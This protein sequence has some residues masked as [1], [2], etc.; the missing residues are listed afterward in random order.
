M[1][2]NSLNVLLTKTN[3]TFLLMITADYSDDP[4]L[5]RNNDYTSSAL[6]QPLSWM[7]HFNFYLLFHIT[8]LGVLGDT[9]L[10]VDY[11]YRP[12]VRSRLGTFI[13]WGFHFNFPSV[14]KG[15]MSVYMMCTESGFVFCSCIVVRDQGVRAP[16]QSPRLPSWRR[17]LKKDI[18]IRFS[19]ARS[20][21]ATD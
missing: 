20:M 6:R 5:V 14:I 9:G 18:R 8:L 21:Q 1:R 17:T 10:F 3:G 15:N 12:T 13:Y 2:V 7:L 19:T 4:P 11:C 16:T